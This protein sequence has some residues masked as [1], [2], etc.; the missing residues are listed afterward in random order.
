MTT[1][2]VVTTN[3]GMIK[4][5]VMGPVT[6]PLRAQAQPVMILVLT[7]IV[8]RTTVAVVTTNAGMISTVVR[9]PVCATLAHPVV[10]VV[11]I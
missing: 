10:R 3:A 1:V 9:D 4:S 2:A 6:V 8:I 11:L 5:V 7:L